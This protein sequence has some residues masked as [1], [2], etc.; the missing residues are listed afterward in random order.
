LHR[1]CP[2]VLQRHGFISCKMSLKGRAAGGLDI[3]RRNLIGPAYTSGAS[4]PLGTCHVA[5][6]RADL[7]RLRG[8]ASTRA[9]ALPTLLGTANSRTGRDITFGLRACS[10]SRVPGRR[11]GDLRDRG[12]SGSRARIENRLGPGPS[13]DATGGDPGQP[14]VESAQSGGSKA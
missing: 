9:I 3:Y 12:A 2:L 5:A 7:R 1:G 13:T 11:F 10:L 6:A 4:A 14:Y 8:T